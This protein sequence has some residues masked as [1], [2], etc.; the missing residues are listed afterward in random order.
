VRVLIV[1]R[2][3]AESKPGG[4]IT[5]LESVAT[6]LRELGIDVTVTTA[7]DPN[8]RGYDVAHLF[9]VFDPPRA[10]RQTDALVRSG[11]PLVITPVWWDRSGLFALAPRV[12]R[13]LR[14]RNT[15]R[16][17]ARLEKLRRDERHLTH[18]AGKGAERWRAAQAE[19]LGR[20]SLVLAGS[21]VEAFACS[22]MLGVHDVPYMV[23]LYG[24]DD[25]AFDVPRPQRR[26]GIICVG[27][28]QSLKNQAMLLYALRDTDLEITLV[29]QCFDPPYG[30]L[31]RR[32]ATPNTRFVERVP[33][34]ELLAMMAHAE[35][36]VL[37][38]WADLPG[39]VSLD[40][41]AVGARV[42]AGTRGSEREYLGP[43]VAYVDP[44]DPDEIY[45]AV[46]G[47][48]ARGPR[49]RG[50][51]LERRIGALTWESNAQITLEAYAR[52]LGGR[53]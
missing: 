3:D 46:M 4:D 47:E 27:R 26:N 34:A 7:L 28:L 6:A 11:V 21:N 15:A 50:D 31:C 40:A 45:A 36:H 44:L 35:V 23:A 52:V 12:E 51:A 20:A 16:I 8:A 22:A 43:D 53:R 29:G 49:D 25:E 5:L 24:V 38:S 19:I 1:S 32:L 30:E 42:V 13:I 17:D 33:R 18:H 39:F 48:I 2:P 9:G 14:D 41:A 37:P 10:R